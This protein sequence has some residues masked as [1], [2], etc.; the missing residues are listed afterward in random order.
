MATTTPPPTSPVLLARQVF[1]TLTPEQ[2]D[3]LMCELM[4]L[5][6]EQEKGRGKSS[7]LYPDTRPC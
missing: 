6:D 5:A 1:E 2:V 3:I 7:T 4:K